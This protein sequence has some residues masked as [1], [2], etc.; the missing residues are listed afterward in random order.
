[1]EEPR[2]LAA[3]RPLGAFEG[4]VHLATRV[5]AACLLATW[6]V[7]LADLLVLPALTPRQRLEAL[8][9]G[10]GLGVL[11]ALA[12]GLGWMAARW[13]L[14]CSGVASRAQA[15]FDR[16][17]QCTREDRQR[18]QRLHGIA[19]ASLLALVG[20]LVVLQRVLAR[21]WRLQ[22]EE[23]A[24][25]VAALAAVLLLI[26]S[27]LCAA[28]LSRLLR[29]AVAWLDRHWSLPQSPSA[30]VA[31]YVAAPTWVLFLL[32]RASTSPLA[33]QLVVPAAV[34]AALLTAVCAV[35]TPAVPR[36]HVASLAIVV[37]GVALLVSAV[38]LQRR[39]AEV[40]HFAAATVA[41][42]L[43]FAA[44]RVG[45][46]VDRDG[47]S[48]LVGQIDCAPWNP[49]IGPHAAERPGNGIDENCDGKDG[50]EQR[51]VLDVSSTQLP[52][53][54]TRR[55][56]V[57]WIIID[58]VR[59]DHVGHHGYLRPTTPYLDALADEAVSFLDAHSQS[60]ATLYSFGSMFTGADPA[61][62][63]YEERLDRRQLAERHTTVAERFRDE[64]YQTAIFL[65]AWTGR[66]Y[67]GVQQ[68]H[69]HRFTTA[70]LDSKGRAASQRTSP[71]VTVQA[72]EFIE[73]ALRVG[74][75]FLATV[76]YHDTHLPYVSHPGHPSFGDDAL[77][78]YDGELAY[79][80]RYVGM[81]L[82]YLR[83]RSGLW[84]ETVVVVT[85]DHG[86]EFGEHGQNHHAHSCYVESTHVPLLLRVPGLAPARVSVPVAL[87]D[88][89]P[90]VLELAGIASGAMTLNGRNLLTPVLAPHALQPERPIYCAVAS[91]WVGDAPFYKRSVRAGPFS[92]MQDVPSGRVE[93]YEVT[94]DR[95]EQRDLAAEP[96]QR[97][98]VASLRSLLAK[99]A[100]GNMTATW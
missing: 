66:Y 52:P 27:L 6:C 9:P 90:T 17:W 34:C 99:G 54:L 7:T 44:V 23:V 55:F 47:A 85:A 5:S 8:L 91:Q 26:P 60:S 35:R 16:A 15:S 18:V 93:L 21:L 53:A 40:S 92:L 24:I 43:G 22:I 80:D 42:R 70:A 48:P 67:S 49:A 45:S 3:E 100:T 12:L 10:L 38:L 86:E 61:A 69:D 58:G 71:L 65:T 72:I 75:P 14:H 31:I 30:F 41:G 63:T 19:C 4:S 78:R 1:L 79:A 73:R 56:N 37:G 13:L 25:G 64:G 68:G 36:K 20:Y 50:L 96:N 97:A 39:R 87:I 98:R 29:L 11:P 77:D 81:L 32:I 51:A 33:A 82:E 94:R 84:D 74:S 57:V 89:A 2:T 83:S 76:Y 95:S 62:L 59:A 46:D 88:I 28:V